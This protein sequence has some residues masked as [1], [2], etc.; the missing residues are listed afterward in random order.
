M[1][2]IKMFTVAITDLNFKQSVGVQISK[3]FYLLS[4]VW[5]G[6]SALAGLG[7]GLY[8]GITTAVGNQTREYDFYYD[9]W[10]DSGRPGNPIGILLVL[11]T[12]VVVPLVTFVGV[13]VSRYVFEWYNAVI[14]TAENTKPQA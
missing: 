11:A 14:H 10:Y 1:S 3:I 4:L 8:F 9:T 13:L 6:L 7:A 2:F 5:H 12:L